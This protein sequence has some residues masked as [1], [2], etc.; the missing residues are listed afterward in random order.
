[1][2]KAAELVKKLTLA[3]KLRMLTLHFAESERLNL[4]SFSAGT[5]VAR[6]Y[7][8]H[9]EGGKKVDISTVFPQPVGLA[10]TFDRDIMYKLGKIA[11]EELRFYWKAEKQSKL[12]LFGPTVDLLR[13]PR[14]GRNEEAYG[15]DPFLSGS[16][17]VAYCTGLT[18]PDSENGYAKTAP[19][20][21]HFCANNHEE[22]RNSDN[23]DVT[24][25]LL[26]EYYYAPFR[27]IISAGK[28]AGLMASYNELGGVPAVMNPDLVSEVK[29]KWGADYVISD[30]GDFS[31]NYLNHKL[32]SSHAEAFAYTIKNGTDCV[33]D[34][35]VMVE[36]AA[37]EALRAGL[38]SESDIDRAVEN[39]LTVREKL[40]E[41]DPDCDY[42]TREFSCDTE[43]FKA[44]NK[45]AAYE[46]VCLLQNDG[47]LPLSRDKKIALIG[48]I[49][50]ENYNDWYTGTASY[51]VSIKDGFKRVFDDNLSFDNG[52]D[53][54][55]ITGID[56]VFEHHDWGES[57]SSYFMTFRDPTSRLWLSEDENGVYN[58]TAEKVYDW[59]TK[60]VFK[61]AYDA[62]TDSYTFKNIFN[63]PLGI[64]DGKIAVSANPHGDRF[65]LNV[66]SDGCERAA[67]LAK[68]AD[69]AVV[70]VGNQPMLVARECYDRKTLK[71]PPAQ[72]KLIRETVKANANTVLVICSSYPFMLRG[73]EN[74]VRAVLYTTHA[75]AELGNAVADVI[76]GAYN[77]AARCPQTWYRYDSDLPSIKDY[78]IDKNRVTYQYFDGEALFPFGHGLSYSEFSYG[79]FTASLREG[80]IDAT[81]SIKN[82]SDID[83]DEVWQIYV[84]RQ[85]R[86]KLKSLCA[87]DRVHIKAGETE[88]FSVKI[89][90]SD[91]EEYNT[92]TGE[93]MPLLLSPTEVLTL[94]LGSSSVDIKKTVMLSI[95]EADGFTLLTRDL[96][97][98]TLAKTYDEEEGTTLG[99]DFNK[100]DWYV[101]FG[102]AGGKLT[103][104]NTD[105]TGAKSIEIAA[106]APNIEAK[107]LIE[108]DG[109]TVGE[110]VIKP[111][112]SHTDYA[113]YNVP[114]KDAAGDIL[115]I[116]INKAANILSI[117]VLR[118]EE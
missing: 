72:E 55:E 103:F 93:M 11:A 42:N 60:E 59:F 101:K 112:V 96:T 24:M 78:R 48:P 106:A 32:F 49:A 40:G 98:R 30:G 35:A 61:P 84:T 77:P 47:I 44:T 74:L 53:H 9:G 58:A 20:L 115:H 29:G 111:Q 54:V 22:N 100:N 81:F 99:F 64:S 65:K 63:K 31:Q 3:E 82:V 33:I 39:T 56:G 17:A 51:Y 7:V 86:D 104:K 8:S 38:I 105:L 88:N 2:K 14:W 1:M 114:L 92:E 113:Y 4:K 108:A 10:S 12:M 62:A 95:S 19:A 36:T 25:K 76:A 43:K 18:E 67:K 118:N 57:N 23:A 37:R 97:K 71:L 75:G 27:R 73:I 79:D 107:L 90:L 89:P 6:G 34:D 83:G 21:K 13:D 41:F 50:D 117:Q 69:T 28:A 94:S 16:Q 15:E 66:V 116:D 85:N 80:F 46:Q 102:D 52:Y 91:L 87:Y 109:K 5:E 70:V 68:D 110:S 26:H 45:R